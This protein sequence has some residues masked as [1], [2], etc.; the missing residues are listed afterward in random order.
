[1]KDTRNTTISIYRILVAALACVLVALSSH[2]L[3]ADSAASCGEPLRSLK[4]VYIEKGNW[5]DTLAA[6][7]DN[8]QA[9]NAVMAVSDW[10]LCSE[11]YDSR[12]IHEPFPP[13]TLHVAF[14]ATRPIDGWKKVTRTEDGR[15]ARYL[16]PATTTYIYREFFCT[17][18]NARLETTFA[19]NAG[20]LA[21]WHNGQ[22]AFAEESENTKEP[23]QKT[24][25][26]CFKKEKNCLLVK[27]AAARGAHFKFSTGGTSMSQ[28]K[29]ELIKHD[30]HEAFLL[31]NTGYFK[32]HERW[33]LA[34][35]TGH[36][37]KEAAA[38][39]AR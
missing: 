18:D 35:D 25:T 3:A 9:T 1:M 33:L 24:I 8:Y 39:T 14:D 12:A 28:L 23:L 20:H 36:L 5:P 16:S 2:I 11:K 32:E 7:R 19:V 37:L 34:R 22:K 31:C 38:S 27:M 13:E 30:G 21:V 15:F 4:D 6:T 26:L 29:K 17:E 10:Y